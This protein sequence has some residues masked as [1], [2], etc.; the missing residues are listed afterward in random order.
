MA[1]QAL[2]AFWREFYSRIGDTHRLDVALAS[3]RRVIPESTIALF[4]RHPQGK[5]F[6][7]ATR[8]SGPEAPEQM[9]QALRSSLDASQRLDALR[10]RYG[11]LPSYLE[12][13]AKEQGERQT[14]L[15]STLLAWS[16]P[17]EDEL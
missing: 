16:R 3:A 10:G 13:V 5:L 6:R 9:L 12:G 15:E 8:R 4:L 7:T 11:Q 14:S 1:D 2:T 17:E